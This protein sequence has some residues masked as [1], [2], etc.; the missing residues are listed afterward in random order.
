M[1]QPLIHTQAVSMPGAW[2]G[3]CFLKQNTSGTCILNSSKILNPG[4]WR[5]PGRITSFLSGWFKMWLMN[6]SMRR[7]SLKLGQMCKNKCNQH[8]HLADEGLLNAMSGRAYL[9]YRTLFRDPRWSIVLINSA[10]QHTA[11]SCT[12]GREVKLQGKAVRVSSLCEGQKEG[13]GREAGGER[14]RNSIVWAKLIS[15]DTRWF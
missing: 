13:E 3:N 7:H 11:R 8:R 15:W 4:L 9:L 14:E 1:R 12:L 5:K 6:H 10:H 2:I